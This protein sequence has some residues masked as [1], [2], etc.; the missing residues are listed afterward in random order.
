[1][2]KNETLERWLSSINRRTG[3]PTTAYVRG[4]GRHLQGQIGHLH[5]DAHSPGDGWTRYRLAEMC[6]AGGGIS[7]ALSSRA[8][9]RS[10][11]EAQVRGIMFG[12]D[13]AAQMFDEVWKDSE[14][15]EHMDTGQVLRLLD[16]LR[17]GR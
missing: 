3:R 4:E 8:C 17:D 1:M 16:Q 9:T 7:H 6:S 5:T 10:E 11:Y 14:R 15:D 2:L 13:L 12:L